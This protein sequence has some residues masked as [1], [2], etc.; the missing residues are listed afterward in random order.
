MFETITFV[1]FAV[2]SLMGLAACCFLVWGLVTGAFK[3][4]EGI[5]HQ[6]LEVE[7][8]EP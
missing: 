3:D 6:V 5:K 1:E 7:K 2:A 4:V 8:N